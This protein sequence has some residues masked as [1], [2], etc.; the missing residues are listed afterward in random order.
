MPT[1]L[2]KQ[3][4][5][6]KKSLEV[7]QWPQSDDEWKDCVA[8]IQANL[9]GIQAICN[10][11]AGPKA[12]V[13]VMPYNESVLFWYAHLADHIMKRNKFKSLCEPEQEAID[14]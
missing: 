5:T 12:Y 7:G 10:K 14:V 11:Q 4:N 2:T 9:K 3:S 13:D 1:S 6:P 8:F